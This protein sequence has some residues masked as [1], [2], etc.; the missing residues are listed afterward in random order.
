MENQES[1]DDL[2]KRIQVIR[3]EFVEPGSVY[4]MNPSDFYSST[5]TVSKPEIELPKDS[6]RAM[7]LRFSNQDFSPVCT[8]SHYYS[9]AS[10]GDDFIWRDQIDDWDL[11]PAPQFD[12]ST[13]VGEM[14]YRAS[15][16]LDFSDRE[17][18][19]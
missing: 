13:A 3:S 15:R 19:D 12:R 4:V 6:Y 18:D 2:V 16:F 7:S 9:G 17:W 10:I 8:M 11:H 1:I 5:Y 14:Q